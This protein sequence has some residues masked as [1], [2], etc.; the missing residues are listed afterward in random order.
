MNEKLESES[1]GEYTTRG[2]NARK[3]YLCPYS[4]VRAT[5]SRLPPQRVFTDISWNILFVKLCYTV[6]WRIWVTDQG[7]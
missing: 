6:N 2:L 3:L 7:G 4:I 1:V 5:I